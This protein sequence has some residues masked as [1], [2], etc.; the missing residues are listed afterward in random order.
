MNILQFILFFYM[1]LYVFI[2]YLGFIVL[3]INQSKKVHSD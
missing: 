3:D 2:R 1:F